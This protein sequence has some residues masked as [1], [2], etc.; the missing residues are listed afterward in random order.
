MSNFYIY[1]LVGIKENFKYFFLNNQPDAPLT[2]M[3]SVIKLYMFRAS[4][5]RIIKEFS[6]VHSALVSFMQGFDDDLQAESGWNCSSILTLMLSREDA[7]N[8]W[9]FITE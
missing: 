9:S 4:A 3:Y 1:L 8:M 2:Q 6:T 5:L 7:R